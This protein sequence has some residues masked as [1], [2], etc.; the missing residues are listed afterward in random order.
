MRSSGKPIID[1]G[2]LS[3]AVRYTTL[4]QA[5]RFMRGLKVITPPEGGEI[6]S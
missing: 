6:M 1:I 2:G 4:P 5:D 3:L